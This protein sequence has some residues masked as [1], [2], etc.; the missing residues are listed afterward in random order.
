MA[1]G[2]SGV[3]WMQFRKDG[4]ATWYAWEAF[5]A[6]R[7]VTLPPAGPGTKSVAVCYKDSL[8]NV[9]QSHQESILVQ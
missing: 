7:Q 4:G 9:S 8:G 6:T 2:S 5:D 3:A 1:T